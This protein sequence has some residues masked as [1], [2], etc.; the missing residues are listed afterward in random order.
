MTV[1]IWSVYEQTALPKI[2]RFLTADRLCAEDTEEAPNRTSTQYVYISSRNLRAILSNLRNR[3]RYTPDDLTE[4][5]ALRS[6]KNTRPPL[7][8][9]WQNEPSLDRRVLTYASSCF[10][11]PVEATVETRLD[12]AVPQYDLGDEEEFAELEL[13]YRSMNSL[14]HLEVPSNVDWSHVFTEA[15]YNPHLF[16]YQYD[17]EREDEL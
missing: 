8:F 10:S 12:A 2:L 17:I 6:W 15:P 9:D 13:D 7:P 1:D 4:Y 14:S 5:S 3:F 11:D 16:T